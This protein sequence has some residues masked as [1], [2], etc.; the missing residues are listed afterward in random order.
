MEDKKQITLKDLTDEQKATMKVDH[1]TLHIPVTAQP[2]Q[3]TFIQTMV[4]SVLNNEPFTVIREDVMQFLLRLAV[5]YRNVLFEFDEEVRWLDSDD[6]MLN[7]TMKQFK[8][9]LDYLQEQYKLD[10]KERV[11]K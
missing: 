6:K 8:P 2:E 11:K 3:I 4:N 1:Y 7:G 9:I 5:S 10:I